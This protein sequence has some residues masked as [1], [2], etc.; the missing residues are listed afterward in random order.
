MSDFSNDDDKTY[1]PRYDSQTGEPLRPPVASASQAGAQAEPQAQAA[2]P[3]TS[4]A[5]TASAYTAPSYATPAY[6]AASATKTPSAKSSSLKTFLMGFL[7]AA[8][9]CILAGGVL[10]GVLSADT[11]SSSGSSGSVS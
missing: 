10:F 4:Q 6:A 11:D 2:S 9:A 7:G 5:Q 1:Y 8:V 3:A